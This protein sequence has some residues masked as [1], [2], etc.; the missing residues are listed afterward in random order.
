MTANNQA[1]KL[2]TLREILATFGGVLRRGAHEPGSC[3]VCAEELRSVA[4]G[5][6]WTDHPA[7]C[8]I[9]GEFVRTLN[10]GVWSSDEARTE[11]CLPL[12]LLDDA[13]AAPEWRDRFALRTIREVLPIALRTIGLDN[14]AAACESASDLAAARD[15]ASRARAAAMMI[16]PTQA[17]VDAACNASMRHQNA[18]VYAVYHAAQALFYKGKSDHVLALGCRILAECHAGKSDR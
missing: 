6:E 8:E 18:A 10:D 1:L 13:S 15:A 14:H 2:E 11:H 12:A 9:V 17:V 16:D 7:G 4:T 3:A 5:E